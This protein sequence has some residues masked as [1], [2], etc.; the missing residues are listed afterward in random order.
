MSGAPEI[1][2]ML[3]EYIFSQSPEVVGSFTNILNT[4]I[5]EFFPTSRPAK[6]PFYAII[7]HWLRILELMIFEA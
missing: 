7:V 6:V 5:W 4:E 2:A 3:A 1:H